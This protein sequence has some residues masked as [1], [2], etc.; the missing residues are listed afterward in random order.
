[1]KK[2]VFANVLMA[3]L[4]VGLFLTVSC[5]QKKVTS[6]PDTKTKQGTQD[7]AKK[8]N[9]LK[10]VATGD[11]DVDFINLDI[12]FDFDSAELTSDAQAVLQSKAGYL[13]EN[14]KIK[15]LI[16]GHCDER[17]TTEYNLALGE[18][19]AKSAQSFLIDLGISAS[20]LS[21]TS[22][23]EEQPAVAG[24]NRDAWERN[25]RGH[26]ELK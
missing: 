17:G 16:E 4:V 7:Q 2:R 19:R 25:R 8:T 14:T 5:A 18:R 24:H 22:Y 10:P 6:E 1:M 3:L 11:D 15:V 26:F 12:Y 21:F 23:G 13:Q 9:P 20:R